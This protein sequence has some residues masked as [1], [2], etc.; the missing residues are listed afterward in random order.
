MKQ[1]LNQYN[2]KTID[3]LRNQIK[4]DEERIKMQTRD[5]N[6][7]RAKQRKCLYWLNKYINLLFIQLTWCNEYGCKGWKKKLKFIS[8]NKIFLLFL[9]SCLKKVKTIMLSKLQVALKWWCKNITGFCDCHIWLSL[10]TTTT[11]FVWSFNF[12]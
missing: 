1:T 9:I 11:A 5:L 4:D 2:Q 12:L 8:T 7:Q 3:I 6:V 10:R